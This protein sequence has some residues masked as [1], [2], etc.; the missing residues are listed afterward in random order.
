MR[1]AVAWLGIGMTL[2]ANI[3]H[4]TGY[5]PAG[6]ITS[7]WPPVALIACV[8]VLAQMLHHK[9]VSGQVRALHRM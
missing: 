7:G 9:T 5:G 8:E 6:V 3:T 4:G 2:W 1:R